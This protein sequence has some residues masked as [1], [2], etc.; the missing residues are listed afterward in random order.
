MERKLCFAHEKTASTIL[1]ARARSLDAG[2]AI[3]IDA[4]DL[5]ILVAGEP[6]LL[7]AEDLVLLDAGERVLH[8]AGDPVLL[9]T[10][11]T[12]AASRMLGL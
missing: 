8:D 10:A 7:D 4:E 5:V 6:I 12:V 2:E 9:D 3:L 1:N 11:E